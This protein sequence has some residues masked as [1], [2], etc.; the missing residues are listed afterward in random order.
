MKCSEMYVD[1]RRRAA[2][3]EIVE[4]RTLRDAAADPSM[5]GLGWTSADFD[6]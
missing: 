1:M 5:D 2:K 4:F 6:A 3:S